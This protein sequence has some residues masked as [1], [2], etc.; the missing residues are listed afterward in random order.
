MTKVS[1]L[2]A[3]RYKAHH[4]VFPLR[5][6]KKR[7]EDLNIKLLFFNRLNNKALQSDAII[8]SS[9]QVNECFSDFAKRYNINF[10]NNNYLPIMELIKRQGLSIIWFDTSDTTGISFPNF[11]E[12]V[13]IYLKQQILKSVVDTENLYY[14]YFYK[15]YFHSFWK[16]ERD[17]IQ[18][19]IKD[20]QR[21]YS[22]VAIGWNLAFSD[23]KTHGKNRI[24]RGLNIAFPSLI[25]N[26][27]FYNS[28]LI[29]RGKKIWFLGD[30]KGHIVNDYHRKLLI[31]AIKKYNQKC[32]SS[33][34][35]FTSINNNKY[36]KLLRESAVVPSPFGLGEICYRDFE[37]LFSGCLMIKPRMDHIK[38]WPN[39]YRPMETY[40]PC[41]WD[42]SDL[43]EKVQWVFEN[44][45]DAQTIADNGQSLLKKLFQ[46]ENNFPHRFKNIVEDSLSTHV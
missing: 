7:L 30:N 34:N 28:P 11:L 12:R 29:N 4:D 18:L 16:S 31:N 46:Q 17:K 35:S 43:E 39:I 15:R 41:R 32:N 42:F 13:N 27:N 38:T 33:N 10:S 19:N 6:H 3:K 14:D 25:N 23:W 26:I 20:M 22:K 44:I 36:N 37:I 40:V 5:V 9:Y 8:I 24:N 45:S 21:S 1:V 2:Y